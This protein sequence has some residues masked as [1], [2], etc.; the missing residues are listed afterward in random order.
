MALLRSVTKMFASQNPAKHH[1]KMFGIF[2]IS[3][4]ISIEIQFSNVEK[5]SSRN[6]MDLE[7]SR[8]DENFS[9]NRDETSRN[10]VS[11][12]RA[13]NPKWGSA[14]MLPVKIC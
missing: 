10:L 11:T 6:P 1:F 7:P 9:K 12:S 13:D 3:R 5:F 14:C 8:R 4:C 2:E